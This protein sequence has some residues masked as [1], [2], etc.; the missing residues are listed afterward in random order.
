MEDGSRVER[1]SDG[2]TYVEFTDGTSKYTD[3]YGETSRTVAIGEGDTSGWITQFDDGS[4]YTVYDNGRE[5]FTD[6]SGFS[7]EILIDP[8]TGVRT[9][10]SSDGTIRREDPDGSFSVIYPDGSRDIGTVNPDG[11]LVVTFADGSNLMVRDDGSETYQDPYGVTTIVTLDAEGRRTEVSS[12][13]WTS[14]TSADGSTIRVT[15]PD[16]Y[17]ENTVISQDGSYVTT[18]SDG[19]SVRYD[20]ETKQTTF[21]GPSGVIEIL[22]IDQDGNEVLTN[23]NG[24]IYEYSPL[25]NT[26]SFID[27][28]GNTQAS[29]RTE[30]GGYIITLENGTVL[31]LDPSGKPLNSEADITE[32]DTTLDIAWGNVGESDDA[33]ERVE[34]NK[35]T[36]TL[37][38]WTIEGNLSREISIEDDGSVI[39]EVDGRTI[40][41]DPTTGVTGVNE[42]FYELGE[43]II[44][45]SGPRSATI[46]EDGTTFT[47]EYEGMSATAVAG[48]TGVTVEIDGEIYE[49]SY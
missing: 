46:S 7:V 40:E 6:P 28:D 10:T 15:S 24:D 14:T 5:S 23:S 21:V 27:A 48:A 17:V 4:S 49:F 26:S 42:I 37:G 29:E 35:E 47:V 13:G 44:N 16:G 18:G 20:A 25:S 45:T 11:D 22:R 32:T 36:N 9:E 3:P 31:E 2:S 1:Y 12:D 19:S 30:D 33:I 34:W 8:E 39:V 41:Y 38:T 43:T